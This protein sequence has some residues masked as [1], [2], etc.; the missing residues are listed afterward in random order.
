MSTLY[1][2]GLTLVSSVIPKKVIEGLS[3]L[4]WLRNKFA[5]SEKVSTIFSFNVFSSIDIIP[6]SF[7]FK[8]IENSIFVDWGNPLT[9]AIVV[10]ATSF[11]TC[12]RFLSLSKGAA[13]LVDLSNFDTSFAV[14]WKVL[15]ASTKSLIRSLATS[16]SPNTDMVTGFSL[17]EKNSRSSPGI[18]S[19]AIF[20]ER[21]TSRPPPALVAPRC[22]TRSCASLTDDVCVEI[23]K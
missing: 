8:P 11:T 7:I 6:L 10:V 2:L 18:T 14:A 15:Y 9:V 21:L 1:P 17:D 4:P 22:K 5:T 23:V 13:V 19:F 3:V 16:V 12:A 20:S